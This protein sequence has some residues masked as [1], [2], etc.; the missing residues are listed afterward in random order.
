MFVIGYS[1][2]LS[3]IGMRLQGVAEIF[4]SQFN[5]FTQ[6]RIFTDIVEVVEKCVHDAVG[7]RLFPA[8]RSV[9][10]G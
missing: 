10:T 3:L 8:R 9:L 6:L 5:F 4:Q 7:L 1:K 2:I